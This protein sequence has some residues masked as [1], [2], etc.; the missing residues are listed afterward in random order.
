MYELTPIIKEFNRF[1]QYY[2]VD[3][4]LFPHRRAATLRLWMDR[5][6]QEREAMLAEVKDQG[7]PK[8][9]NPYFYVQEFT[10][11]E[12]ENLN[13]TR[14]VERL[15]KTTKLVIARYKNSFGTYTLADAERHA[16]DIVRGL[17]FDYDMYLVNRKLY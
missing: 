17:N 2:Q 10:L 13:G 4:Q 3:E 1:W 8:G 16:M 9:K 14:K 6:A 11:P 15:I 12:P 5:T 7:G